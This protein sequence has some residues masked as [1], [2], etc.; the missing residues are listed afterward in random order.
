MKS[1]SRVLYCLCASIISLD[2]ICYLLQPSSLELCYLTSI[3]CMF[4]MATIPLGTSR[5]LSS[6]PLTPGRRSRVLM[7]RQSRLISPYPLSDAQTELRSPTC[8]WPDMRW[9]KYRGADL[10]PCLSPPL[11]VHS[12]VTDGSR[13]CEEGSTL[14][15]WAW[16]ES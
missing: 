11:K 12:S 3:Y 6:K 1:G 13:R 14:F 16:A 7:S 5:R 10:T 2:M 9:C 4:C 8:L 15:W